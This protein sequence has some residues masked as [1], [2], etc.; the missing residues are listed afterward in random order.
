ME[1]FF[2]TISE[3]FSALSGPADYSWIRS[4]LW[5]TAF[6]AMSLGLYFRIWLLTESKIIVI[7]YPNVREKVLYD[8]E[9]ALPWIKRTFLTELAK[10]AEAR[11]GSVRFY[12]W[13]NIFNC[14]CVICSTIIWIGTMVM[15]NKA[16][17]W[18][19]AKIFFCFGIAAVI[20]I[21]LPDLIHLYLEQKQQEKK[22]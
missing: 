19:S 4:I 10:K 8:R 12:W 6:Y 18:L 7:G 3:F 2:Q 13:F 5:G 16:W 21:F 11:R 15:R 17:L 1:P 20:A 9:K 14:I 22:K